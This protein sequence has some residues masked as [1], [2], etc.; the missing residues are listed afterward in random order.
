ML[1]QRSSQSES[2][3]VEHVKLDQRIMPKRWPDCQELILVQAGE[4]HL[5]VNGNPVVYGPGDVFFLAAQDQ[6]SFS[7]AQRTSVYRLSFSRFFVDSLPARENHTWGYLDAATSPC[8]GSIATDV[9]DQDKLRALVVMLL[10]EKQSLRPS[11]DNCIVE[12]LMAVILSLVCRLL[13]RSAPTTSVQPTHSSEIT[14]RV[15]AYITRYIGEPHRLRMDT[16]ADAFNYSP[17]HLS[18]LFKQQVG[19]SIQ[20]FIIRHKLKLVARRLQQTSL[21]VSEVADEFGFT[22]VC[23]LNKL[24]KRHY[25]STPT[26]Y[27][28]NL[29]ST[30]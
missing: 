16:I 24:F 3:F 1:T 23:H 2:W 4:G 11:S 18:A 12:S 7:M 25:K 8:L 20:Q 13:A 27:R 19:A 26:T 6:H 14:R 21:T 5:V 30:L 28:L 17:S 29:L 22:D 9:A 15:I 10:A